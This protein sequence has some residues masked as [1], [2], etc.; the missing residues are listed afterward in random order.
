MQKSKENFVFTLIS[1]KFTPEIP[2]NTVLSKHNSTHKAWFD[3]LHDDLFRIWEY[4]KAGSAVAYEYMHSRRQADLV[5][6]H[7][8][9]NMGDKYYNQFVTY[10][11]Y[12]RV[13]TYVDDCFR[14]IKSESW[15]SRK[16]K[17]CICM[18]PKKRKEMV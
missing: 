18:K 4:E 10:A 14:D 2:D 8:W 12:K 1:R 9:F 5:N 11:E 13:R 3:R 6:L 15:K 16:A 17:F 7:L